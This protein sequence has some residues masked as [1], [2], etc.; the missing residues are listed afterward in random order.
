MIAHDLLDLARPRRLHLL[1]GLQVTLGVL[2]WLG[3]RPDTVGPLEW[4]LTIAHVLGG[5]LLL[6]Q[7]AV[8][9]CWCL[10]STLAAPARLDGRVPRHAGEVL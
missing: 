10:R 8:V 2:A 1:L 7:T 9:W 5:G 6:A 4:T 3:F